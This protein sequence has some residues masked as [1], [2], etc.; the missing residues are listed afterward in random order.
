MN[1]KLPNETYRYTVGSWSQRIGRIDGTE[2]LN[3]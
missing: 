3:G 2:V 1:H